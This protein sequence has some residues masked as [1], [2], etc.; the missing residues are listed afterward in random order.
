M[1][2]RARRRPLVAGGHAAHTCSALRRRY[3]FSSV[4]HVPRTIIASRSS[5]PSCIASH[6]AREPPRA[7]NKHK[8]HEGT[9][10]GK[11]LARATH[12]ANHGG[13]VLND[14]GA[15]V[16][17]DGSPFAPSPLLATALVVA[18]PTQWHSVSSRPSLPARPC[19]PSV[20]ACVVGGWRCHVAGRGCQF[21]RARCSGSPPP[22]PRRHYYSTT[23]P[24]LRFLARLPPAAAPP[25]PAPRPRPAIPAPV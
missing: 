19:P 4:W 22:P 16:L 12:R 21:A 10:V 11:A 17:L 20:V 13:R 23:Y 14:G 15:E 5:L 1:P 24:R 7:R 6:G 9:A 18:G 2:H 3:G 8:P 25:R